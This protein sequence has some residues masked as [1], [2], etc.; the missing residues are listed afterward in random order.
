MSLADRAI[1]AAARVIAPLEQRMTKPVSFTSRGP[2]LSDE[3]MLHDRGRW[4]NSAVAY[5]CIQAISSN[6][7]SLRLQ[8][9]NEDDVEQD[10]E[11]VQLWAQPN[12]LMSGRVFG[13]YLWQRLETR[14]ETFVYLDRGESG[15]G[16][17]M[18]LWPIFGKV[19]VH[20]DKNLAGEVVGATVEIGGQRVPLL[21][22]EF[23]WLRYPDG[24]S[25]WGSLAPL[26]AAA[27]AV[28]LDSAARMWQEGELRNGARPSGVVYLGDL[29][30]EQHAEVVAS[31]RARAEGPTNAG[32][33]LFVSSATPAKF[34]R[35]SLT[36][37]ELGWLDTRRNAW[38]EVMLG[39]GVPK[40]YLMGGATH[41]NRAA[42]RATLWSDAIVPKLE[43]VAGEIARQV[44]Q[45]TKL[46]ARFDTDDVD[47]LHESADAIANRTN[48]AVTVDVMLLDEARAEYGLEPL[49]GG[50]GQLTLSAYR[51]GVLLE[52]QQTLLQITQGGADRALLRVQQGAN[53]KSFMPQLQLPAERVNKR[54]G[55]DFDQAQAEYAMHE[56][57]GVRAVSRLAGRQQTIVLNN[58]HK[59]FG[60]A[61]RWAK[62]RAEM[63]ET[64][65]GL[66]EIRQTAQALDL[67]DSAQVALR[68]EI[69]KLLS[70]EA[71]EDMTR[72][73]L[74]AFMH[75][76][77][78][79]GGE[80]T[81]QALGVNFDLFEIDVLLE[82]DARRDVLA[83]LVTET[84][85][86]VLEDRVLLQ[87][88]ANGETV[89]E[90][91]VRV[92]SVFTDLSSWRAKMIARTETVGGFNAASH[93]TASDSG[94]AV[95]RVWLATG[96]SRTRD[97]HVTA[98]GETLHTFTGKYSN[99]CQYP[100]DPSAPP[101]ET[102]MCRCVEQYETE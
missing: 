62:Y 29:E 75:N 77:W 46:R 57:V 85:R 30:A 98:D 69:D 34:E 78:S 93:R 61:G 47:A 15:T 94:V 99:G 11:L 95:A 49:P 35:M 5:R 26:N 59:L 48:S 7:S 79:R 21:P 54:A 89:D 96:D 90:L 91:A 82:M 73:E 28:G 97:S 23:L 13:E 72:A 9:L 22:S 4:A 67:P 58:L 10:N 56:R 74:E 20:V 80:N 36:P 53:D 84:T 51:A 101:E 42:A 71:A 68:A 6:A 86:Q 102:I 2:S 41:E 66:Q 32:R 100:G 31:Y 81:A 92:R 12:P 63:M 25:E 65:N 38:E 87:G 55:L 3:F 45:D 14:G 19:T 33:T 43:V 24:D 37:A 27:H 83:Q 52:A 1:Q 17:L 16:P 64:L 44:L 76:V 88:V 8:V 40:D 70:A 50:I 18:G 60:R 39:F